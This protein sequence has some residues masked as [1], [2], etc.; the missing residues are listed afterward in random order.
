MI[1]YDTWQS[2]TAVVWQK[3]EKPVCSAG[4]GK[5]L[6]DKR[7]SNL[8]ATKTIKTKQ[9]IYEIISL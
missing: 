1:E 5:E 6:P 8:T 4:N 2:P 7:V 3:Q 9:L